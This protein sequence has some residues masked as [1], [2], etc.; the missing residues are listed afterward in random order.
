MVLGMRSI[1]HGCTVSQEKE[2]EVEGL[3]GRHGTLAREIPLEAQE[4]KLQCKQRFS[5]YIR[6]QN[7]VNASLHNRV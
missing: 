3:Q 7:W 5:C 2:P 6:E 1:G 4:R